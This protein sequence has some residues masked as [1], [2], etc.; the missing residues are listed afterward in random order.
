MAVT[1]GEVWQALAICLVG[2]AFVAASGLSV[3]WYAHKRGWL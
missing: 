2:G 3:V 1:W